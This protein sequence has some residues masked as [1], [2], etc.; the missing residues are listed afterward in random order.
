M[1]A[2]GV[3]AEVVAV[4]E[5]MGLLDPDGDGPLEDM[6]HYTLRVA[7]A[8][9]NV[10]IAL[11]RLGVSTALVSAVGDDPFGRLIRRTLAQQGV[12][13]SHVRVDDTARSGVFFKERFD[14][15]LRRV[16]Y[17]RDGSAAARLTVPHSGLD[18]MPVA[19]VLVLSG[20]SLGLG[21]PGGLASVARAALRRTRAAGKI[22]VFDANVRPGLWDGERAAEDF[23]EIR[24]YVDIVLAGDDELSVLLPGGLSS[25]EAARQLC[26]AGIRAVVV[27][28]GSRGATLVEPDRT[29]EIPPFAVDTIVDPV[30][31]GDAFAAG[32]VCGLLHEWPLDD[33]ARLGA[34]LGAAAV[35]V[36]GDWEALP[37]GRDPLELLQQYFD[38]VGLVRGMP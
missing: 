4:G 20:I 25:E 1:A 37:T 6:S 3:P 13:V 33:S 36:S 2:A 16:Y 26:S 23:A 18:R 32:I 28:H 35:T 15:G 14:D 7:G 17:Y 8:E 5:V 22:T 30:G 29:F 19:H 21:A 34:M 24:E 31:A 12:D 27:K 11:S 9:A 10:L 38:H